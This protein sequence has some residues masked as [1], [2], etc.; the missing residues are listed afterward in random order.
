M[1]IGQLG[2]QI[3]AI[4]LADWQLDAQ[5]LTTAG[6]LAQAKRGLHSWP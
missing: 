6:H 2:L 3:G 4:A 1:E 5:H